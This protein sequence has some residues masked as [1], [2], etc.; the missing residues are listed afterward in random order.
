MAQCGYLAESFW[1]HV[2]VDIDELVGD[3]AIL[4]RKDY[5][6]DAVN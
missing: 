4:N 1:Y 5:C 2:Q 6:T 3:E